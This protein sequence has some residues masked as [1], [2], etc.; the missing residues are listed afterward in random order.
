[1]SNLRI[2]NVPEMATSNVASRHLS[3]L[4]IDNSGWSV[5]C[6][7]PVNEVWTGCVQ[8]T[9]YISYITYN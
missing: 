5:N 6:T 4:R 3:D 9:K 8:S 1:M 2:A 7:A